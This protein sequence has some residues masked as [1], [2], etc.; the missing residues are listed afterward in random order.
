MLDCQKPATRNTAAASAL[1]AAAPLRLI[2]RKC[3]WNSRATKLLSAPTKCSTSTICRLP[4]SAPRV[5]NTTVSTMAVK[6]RMRTP[7]PIMTVVLAMETSL[8]TQVR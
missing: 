2:F 6:T 5:A 1:P 3:F 8:S 7:T 4:E